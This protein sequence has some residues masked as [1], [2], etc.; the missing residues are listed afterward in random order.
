MHLIP[1]TL[2][3]SAVNLNFIHYQ[4]DD[5]FIIATLFSLQYILN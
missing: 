3:I 1:K 5:Y 2:Y 4:D